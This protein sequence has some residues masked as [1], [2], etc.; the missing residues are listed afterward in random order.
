MTNNFFPIT[1]KYIA[2]VSK[3]GTRMAEGAVLLKISITHI[4]STKCS[5]FV[6]ST[7]F[8]RK[9]ASIHG[10]TVKLGAYSKSILPSYT[11]LQEI[12]IRHLEELFDKFFWI[13]TARNAQNKSHLGILSCSC[14]SN[15]Q[16]ANYFANLSEDF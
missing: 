3:S 4:H 10:W 6:H 12:L 8:K 5:L 11:K 7:K 14:I 2:S 9:K 15:F 16:L 13:F 1:Y